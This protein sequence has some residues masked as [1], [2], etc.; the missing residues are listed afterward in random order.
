MSPEGFVTGFCDG[1]RGIGLSANEALLNFYKFVF[2][3]G[4]E[5][6]GKVTICY[7]QQLLQFIK[8]YG[9]IYHECAHDA[10]PHTAVEKFV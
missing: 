5:V 9:I 8:V 2:F 7:L 3:Q 4:L 10:Q 1:I 6:A